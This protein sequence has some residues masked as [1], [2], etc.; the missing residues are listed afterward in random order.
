MG[1]GV[2]K[3]KVELVKWRIVRQTVVGN[4]CRFVFDTGVD[5]RQ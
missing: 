1:S 4:R 5:K 2:N 3:K